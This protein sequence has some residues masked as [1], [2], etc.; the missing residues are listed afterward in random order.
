MPDVT[1]Y[2]TK[3][4]ES[5]HL[6][7]RVKLE[8]ALVFFLRE[9]VKVVLCVRV[10]IPAAARTA[11][12]MAGRAHKSILLDSDRFGSNFENDSSTNPIPCDKI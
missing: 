2:V 3:R 12:G 8:I 7:F 4:I 10:S 6:G 11:P 1:T 5:V 9:K